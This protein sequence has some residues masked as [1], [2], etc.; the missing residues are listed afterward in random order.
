MKC[1]HTTAI[2]LITAAIAVGGEFRH[3]GDYLLKAHFK[4]TGAEMTPIPMKPIAFHIFTDGVTIRMSPEGEEE[5]YTNFEIYRSDGIS[6]QRS[7]TGAL[8]VIPGVQAS[9]SADG[10]LRHLRLSR[11]S[12]TITTFPG[13]SDQTIVSYAVAATQKDPD[14]AAAKP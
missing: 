9:S 3:V 14:P 10:T 11:E 2:F 13:V 4:M 5:S 1:L 8:E 7:G 6:R 12:L